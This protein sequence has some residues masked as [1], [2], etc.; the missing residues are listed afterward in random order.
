MFWS[1]V[2]VIAV[3]GVLYSN[4]LDGDFVF[5]DHVAIIGNRDVVGEPPRDVR[6]AWA[7]V[8]CLFRNDYWGTPLAS[9]ASHKSYRPLTVLSFRANALLAGVGG[10]RGKVAARGPSAAARST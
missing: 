8:A 2:T 9:P 7:Q 10:G 1:Y 3:A 5:D 4:S 6:D